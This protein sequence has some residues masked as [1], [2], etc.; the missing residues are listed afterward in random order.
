MPLSPAL[1]ALVVAIAC[2]ASPRH[3]MAHGAAPGVIGIAARKG[4]ELRMLRLTEGLAVRTAAGG[5]SYVCAPSWGAPPAPLATSATGEA[6]WLAAKGGMVQVAADGSVAR[7]V[8]P[9]LDAANVRALVAVGGQAFA[10]RQDP[11]KDAA[12]KTGTSLWRLSAQG[13][14]QVWSSDD[15]WL[16]A[17]ADTDGAAVLLASTVGGVV[18]LARVPIAKPTEAQVATLA[19][20]QVAG[21]AVDLTGLVASLHV[22]GGKRYVNLFDVTRHMVGRVDGDPWAGGSG[23]TWTKIASDYP[24]LYGPVDVG[25]LVVVSS[26][27]LRR[28]TATGLQ[29]IDDNRWYTCLDEAD[30]RSHVCARTQL[31]ELGANGSVGSVRFALADLKPPSLA[32]LDA[33]TRNTCWIEWETFALQAGFDPGVPADGLPAP[34]VA[35]DGGC[36]ATGRRASGCAWL[37]LLGMSFCFMWLSRLRARVQGQFGACP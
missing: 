12:G 29:T 3:A 34:K 35:D 1:L 19:V 28:I 17:A 16:A 6:T 32:R 24:L 10:V 14:V 7:V 23:A 30:G 25:G 36:V 18:R 13:A 5:W 8:S 33:A 21:P 37:G 27:M 26:T 20:V 15:A 11:A 31:F 2:L 22:T 4:A 9:E